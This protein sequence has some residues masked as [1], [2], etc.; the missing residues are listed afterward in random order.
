MTYGEQ[1]F[2]DN[3]ILILYHSADYECNKAAGW[4]SINKDDIV[5]TDGVIVSVKSP[6]AQSI[7]FLFC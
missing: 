4:L 7:S 1:H 5:H 3:P 2:R 6:A